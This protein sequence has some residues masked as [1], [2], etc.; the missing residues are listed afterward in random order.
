MIYEFAPAKLNLYLHITGRRDAGYH[1]LDSLATFAGVGDDI[2]LEPSEKFR[3]IVEGPQAAA[4][5]SE[6]TDNNLVVKA[7]HSLAELTGKKLNV[8]ITLVKKLPVAAG[9]GG[10]SSDAAAG[11]RALAKHWG[12][13]PNDPCLLE[14]AS[15]HGQDVPV[16]LRTESAY[17]TSSGTIPAPVLPYTD[18]VL[19]NPNKTLPTVDVYQTYKNGTAHFSPQ[20]QLEGPPK[21]LAT[22][23]AALK[24]R[25]NDLFEPACHLMPEIFAVK[26]VLDHSG[27]CLLAR[28]SGS[29]ATCFGL[30]TDRNAARNAAS[31]IMEIR[32]NWWVVQSYIPYRSD[33]RQNF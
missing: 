8:V 4:L 15:R 12:I 6:P 30:Y 7:A 16:C 9:I 13:S 18:I 22:L 11:L 26:E 25:H 2:R 33:P 23:T 3:F 28:M 27:G 29:G 5:R 24:M 21:D 10:G 20:A 19:V 32:P 14:A 17:M 1:E 31:D